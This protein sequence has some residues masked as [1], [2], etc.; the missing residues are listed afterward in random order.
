MRLCIY[1]LL[2]PLA[3]GCLFDRSGV[4]ADGR[5]YL[6]DLVLTAVLRE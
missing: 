3:A 1:L 2:L 5:G 6:A 4:P